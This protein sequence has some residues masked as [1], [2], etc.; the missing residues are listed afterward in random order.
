MDILR[1]TMF[2][3][4]KIALK[5][6]ALLVLEEVMGLLSLA[7]QPLLLNLAL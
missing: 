3:F 1:V 4:P 5:H 7:F 6:N 2:Y